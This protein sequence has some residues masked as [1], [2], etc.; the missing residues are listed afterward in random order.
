MSDI[1]FSRRWA[2]FQF[3]DKLTVLKFRAIDHGHR[4][5]HPDGVGQRLKPEVGV[6]ESGNEADLGEAE[7][8][9]DVLGP[10]LHEERDAVAALEALARREEVGHAIAVLVNLEMVHMGLQQWISVLS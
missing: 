5:G 4:L 10:V 7:P 3:E 8:D 2:K 6:D 1:L 9:G